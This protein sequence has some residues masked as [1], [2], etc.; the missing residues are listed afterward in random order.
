MGAAVKRL[1]KSDSLRER[2]GEQWASSISQLFEGVEKPDSI[3]LSELR[4]EMEP[5][6]DE[7]RLRMENEIEDTEFRLKL[8]SDLG[9]FDQFWDDDFLFT[10]R[11][12]RSKW[13]YLKPHSTVP[14][15]I[16]SHA[17]KGNKNITHITFNGSDSDSGDEWFL[18]AIRDLPWLTSISG[19]SRDPS[20][21][22][23]IYRRYPLFIHRSHL[24]PSNDL[25]PF[26]EEIRPKLNTFSTYI[27]TDAGIFDISLVPLQ[28]GSLG[29]DVRVLISF[30]APTSGQNLILRLKHSG[31]EHSRPLLVT[32]GST[33]IEINPSTKSSITIDDITLYPIQDHGP[34]ESESDRLSFEPGIRNDIVIQFRTVTT[35]RHGHILHDIE[36]LDED[37]LEYPRMVGHTSGKKPF[38]K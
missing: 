32:L 23:E 21:Y 24:S 26:A 3:S 6:D 37:G 7:I 33:I 31:P 25:I 28:P 27:F 1:A 11:Y 15:K 5:L 17:L 18:T 22:S 14:L 38:A 35:G 8:G 2:L 34:S 36:L 20:S 9:R 13:L 29:N 16:Y 4:R 19:G 10:C 30:V 12:S